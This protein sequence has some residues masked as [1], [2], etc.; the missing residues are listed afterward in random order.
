MVINDGILPLVLVVDDQKSTTEVLSKIFEYEGYRV[1]CVHNGEDALRITGALQ[2][3]L[4]LLDV[5]MP[6]MSG[7]EVLERLRK[8]H[9]TANI[10]T[11]L[12]TAKDTPADVARGLELGADDYLPKPFHPRELLARARSKIRAHQLEK[13]LQRRT[14]ELEALLRVGQELNQYLITDELLS[15]I[16]YLVLDLLPGELAVIYRLD[17][18]G[19]IAHSRA[20]RKDGTIEEGY[21]HADV[22]RRF[23][24]AGGHSLLWPEDTAI[25]PEYAHGLAVPL[26]QGARLYGVIILVSNLRTYDESH[27]RL[28][29]GISRQAGLALHNTELY[30]IQ[31][32]YAQHLEEMVE[33]RTAELRSAQELLI[34]SEKLASLGRMAAGIA[35]EINNPLMP[36]KVN[37]EGMLEDLQ[38]NM[39]VS[40]QDIHKTLESISRI[41]RI[42]ERFLQFSRHTSSDMYLV[43]LTQVIEDVVDFNRNFFIKENMHLELVLSPLPPIYGNR[44]QLEQVFLNLVINARA[45]MQNGDT[46]R[47]EGEVEGNDVVVRV[48]DTGSGIARENLDRIFE[49]FMTTKD[50]GTGLG[51][52]ISYGIIENHNGSIVVE[53]EPGQ[54]AVFTIRL[55]VARQ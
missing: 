2:P 14:Q 23:V 36:A 50:N 28:F 20:S 29:E 10:P 37:L 11:I 53:S 46:L 49:P 45:A 7:F 17:E 35:H 21:Q 26:N 41:E 47:I 54:G 19:G 1:Q 9:D 34:R 42:V 18:N 15:L 48:M 13:A 31:A 32:Q 44:D 12:I 38:A 22:I 6:G 33:E 51:L 16:L 8:G 5:M 4:I 43:E 30:E 27:L 40:A 25:L 3:D 55:P 39:P 52:F 24:D